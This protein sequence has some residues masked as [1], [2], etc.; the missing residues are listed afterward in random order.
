MASRTPSDGTPGRTVIFIQRLISAIAPPLHSLHWKIFLLCLASIFL[1]GVYFAWKV[2]QSIER[3]HLRS[4]E[5]G[6]IDT[7]LVVAETWS[8]QSLETLPTTRE[9]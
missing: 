6:M 4:T 5:Q 1:P 8:P 9:I 3:S 2:G 7:A